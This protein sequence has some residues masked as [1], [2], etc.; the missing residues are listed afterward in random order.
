MNKFIKYVWLVAAIVSLIVVF[1]GKEH[2]IMS[3]AIS[4]IMYLVCRDAEMKD[5]RHE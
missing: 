1:C 4:T 2:H 3:L 5:E